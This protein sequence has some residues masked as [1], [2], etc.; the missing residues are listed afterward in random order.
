MGA[1][2]AEQWLDAS[3]TAAEDAAGPVSDGVENRCEI[4]QAPE[5]YELCF[6]ALSD[7]RCTFRFP[8]DEAGH[9]DLDALSERSRRE[10][11]YAR[12]LIGS[13]LSRPA[14]RPR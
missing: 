14:I 1:S 5:C 12:A 9:V 2:T 6:N 10:Y 13:V 8:C 11:L 7:Q 3:V 4:A